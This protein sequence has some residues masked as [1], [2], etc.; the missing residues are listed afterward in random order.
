MAFNNAYAETL[1]RH[2]IV[3]LDKHIGELGDNEK[4]KDRFR[5]VTRPLITFTEVQPTIDFI[6]QRQAVK[7]SVFLIVSGRLA[8]EIV[9]Q[10]YD[11]ECVIQI[12]IFC[13]NMS[14][15]IDWAAEYINKLL[16]FDSDEELL[17]RLT[18]EIAKYLMEEAKRYDQKNQVELAAGLLDW[19]DW[20][21]ND[22]DTLQRANCKTMREYIRKQRE[23][24]N[25]DNQIV[26]PNQ[27]NN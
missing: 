20:L 11:L 22:A 13:G 19:A 16:M 1:R 3:W 24:L 18:N 2:N 27:F 12:F 26:H 25:T 4:M 9:P 6:R 10:I 14:K 7:R 8:L 17:I 23:K 21:Y 5:R 15:Y